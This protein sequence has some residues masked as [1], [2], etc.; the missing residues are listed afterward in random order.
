MRLRKHVISLFFLFLVFV[1]LEFYRP[2]YL[3][4][5]NKLR[6][7]FSWHWN[8]NW[9]WSWGDSS[10]NNLRSLEELQSLHRHLVGDHL[11]HSSPSPVAYNISSIMNTHH[12][13]ATYMT[14]HHRT[15]YS[16]IPLHEKRVLIWS[17]NSETMDSQLSSLLSSFLFALLTSRSFFIDMEETQQLFEPHFIEWDI[18]NTR[19]KERLRYTGRSE[20]NYTAVLFDNEKERKTLLQEKHIEVPVKFNYLSALKHLNLDVLFPTKALHISVDREFISSLKQNPEYNWA[21]R[22]FLGA[23]DHLIYSNLMKFLFLPPS[24]ISEDLKMY[25]QKFSEYSY[26][27]GMFYQEEQQ[28]GKVRDDAPSSLEKEPISTLLSCS[29]KVLNKMTKKTKKA[30]FLVTN[31]DQ[32]TTE[33]KKRY[34]NTLDVINIDSNH[35]AGHLD[36]FVVKKK[37]MNWWLMGESNIVLRASED[38]GLSPYRQEDS[39]FLLPDHLPLACQSFATDYLISAVL[40]TLLLLF[41][42]TITLKTNHIFS[43]TA[44]EG[45]LGD[46]DTES[47]VSVKD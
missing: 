43:F 7:R 5:I 9:N 27:L 37:A 28:K 40:F 33:V 4:K 46:F 14:F 6:S 21:I 38:F 10:L 44:H 3:W 34:S 16:D 13:F 35:K 30:I 25:L 19:I 24:S 29:Q 17:P 31:N 32:L 20:N 41:F 39:S 12:L 45:D 22:N 42:I 2:Q 1:S 18:H 47:T 36:V 15:I 11:H 8:W 23:E 26:I